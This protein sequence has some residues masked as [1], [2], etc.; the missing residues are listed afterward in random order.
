MIELV[1]LLFI[2]MI[3]WHD[4][5]IGMIELVWLLFIGMINKSHLHF[6]TS[7]C[8]G[9]NRRF[10]KAPHLKFTTEGIE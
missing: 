7:K 9:G 2:G 5:F 10:F 1:W 6:F 4:L 8:Y 3:Y